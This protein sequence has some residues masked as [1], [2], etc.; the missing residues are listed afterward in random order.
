MKALFIC[1]SRVP[2]RQFLHRCVA[3][4]VVCLASLCPLQAAAPNTLADSLD[5]RIGQLR[6]LYEPVVWVG[7]APPSERE[8]RSL[9]DALQKIGS[10]TAAPDL[11]DLEHF[12]T[13]F[14]N[15]PW[16]ASLHANLGRYD[17]DHGLYTRALQHWE[18]AWNRT[19]AAKDGPAKR[20]ADFAF[21]YWVKLLASLGRMETLAP[22]FAETRGR[23]FDA[24]PL[25]QQINAAKE[26]YHMMLTAPGSCF[27]C[28][29][30]AL[31]SFGR[32]VDG[33]AFPILRL[34]QEPSP[35][36]GFT[37]SRLLQL[38]HD[39]G[40]DLVAAD[41]DADETVVAPS[42][43]HWKQDHYAAILKRSRGAFL[44]ADPTFG[45]R[46]WLTLQEIH[47]EATGHFLVA[48]TNLPPQWK[49]LAL[50]QTDRIFGRGSAA[51]IGDQNDTCQNGSG[52]ST[53][54]GGLAGDSGGDQSNGA[55]GSAG[56]DGGSGCSSCGGGGLAANTFNLLLPPNPPRNPPM[57]PPK[58]PMPP[59]PPLPPPCKCDG[60]ASQGGSASTASSMC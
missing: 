34:D 4:A 42:V 58:P 19:K 16:A 36:S 51:A 17:Y 13:E 35:Q 15:S 40:L 2:S 8:T 50:A 5:A 18:T 28:G 41:W 52:G 32:Q 43:V 20:V 44:V 11:Q 27:K 12:L 26:G 37:M 56:S 38:G 47:E 23:V 14:P 59:R 3:C 55:S 29:T 39:A 33:A 7:A 24:G 25:Q 6:L 57:S 22:L 31:M 21:A 30:F 48:R 9:W 53:P 60:S 10:Q 45:K 49:P 54:A 46:R 1:G